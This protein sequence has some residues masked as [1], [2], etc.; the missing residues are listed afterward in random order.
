MIN[1]II[2]IHFLIIIIGMSFI[3]IPRLVEI[4]GWSKDLVGTELI[5][6]IFFLTIG[7]SFIT[8]I[9]LIKWYRNLPDAIIDI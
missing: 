3:L 7:G 6:S 1:I 4:E 5:Y 9:R 2:L 8:I